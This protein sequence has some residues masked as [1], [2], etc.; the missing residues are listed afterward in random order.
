MKISIEGG[1]ACGKTTVLTKLQ[2]TIR[3]PVFLE[4][5][6]KWTLL[7]NFYKDTE[8]WGFTFN[9]EVIMSMSKWKNN[10]Y[11]SLYERSPNSCRWVFTQMQYEQGK[12]CK[13]EID[14]FDKLCETFSWDQDCL[15]YIK[16]DPE[17][18]Y[19]RMK[20]RDR[21]CEVSVS[22]EYLKNLDTKHTY[23]I[24]LI[25]E[26]KPH[27]K[28]YIIDGNQDEDAVYNEILEILKG[29]LNI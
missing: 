10:N 15:I 9:I 17:V 3:I 6:D 14:L 23:M 26:K 11:D 13:K 16:T 25:N 22:L 12:L 5:I 20:K 29:L 27:I 1:I 28:V 18:C 8:R 4:P 21:K 2:N 19:E 7:N 24:N